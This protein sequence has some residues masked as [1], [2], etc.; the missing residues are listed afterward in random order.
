MILVVNNFG[1]FWGVNGL[2]W[3]S[4]FKDVLLPKEGTL[5]EC[6]TLLK[7]ILLLKSMTFLEGNWHRKT[8]FFMLLNQHRRQCISRQIK[9]LAPNWQSLAL[10]WPA[11]NIQEPLHHSS[12]VNFAK[13]SRCQDAWRH[14]NYTNKTFHKVFG[15]KLIEYHKISDKINIPCIKKVL[16][17]LLDNY[18]KTFINSL[19]N[20]QIWCQ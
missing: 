6:V 10:I 14:K 19:P 13:Y 2:T 15:S 5:P 7:S 9:S 12:Q 4:L 18:L 17:N 1:T 20:T 3:V 8:I 11:S 16:F